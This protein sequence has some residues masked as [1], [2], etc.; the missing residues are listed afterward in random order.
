FLAN[1]R[2]LVATVQVAGNPA[3]V[4]AVVGQIGV[5]QVQRDATHLR[6][7]HA[8][9]YGA[10]GERNLDHDRGAVRVQDGSDGNR[11]GVE[12]VVR[13]ALVAGF[14]DDLAEVAVAIQQTNGDE[15]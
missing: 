9:V 3:V 13:F 1:A 14:V 2:V 7:P 11:V 8:G 5:E 10:A 12:P 4:F 15:R 6:Q